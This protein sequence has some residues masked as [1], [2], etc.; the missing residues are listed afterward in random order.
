MIVLKNG[1][2]LK[3][4]A[5]MRDWLPGEAERRRHLINRIMEKISL[6]GY[7]EIATPLLEYCHILTKGEKQTGDDQLYKLVD[8]DGSVL[9]LR[10]EMTIPIAR[11][12]GS[13]KL[14]T[15]PL[16]LMYGGQ[17]FRYEN[18][19]AGRLREF[20]QVGVELI[21]EKGPEADGEI[22]ALVIEALKC[23][24]L[25]EFT[26]SLG[27]T[28]VLE[29]LQEGLSWREEDLDELR[30]L[31]LEKDFAG[32]C[33]LFEKAGMQAK[34]Q[35]E[36][37]RLLTHPVPLE[38]IN[39]INGGLPEGI[40]RALNEL[41]RMAEVLGLYGY[42]SYIQVDLST[43]RRQAYYSG[44]VFEIYTAG[45]GYPIGG[46]GRYD[47]LLQLFGKKCPATGFALGIERL[48]LSLQEEDAG[49]KTI[50]LAGT[51]DE[52]DRKAMVEK[53]RQL[54]VQ[55]NAAVVSLTASDKEEAE[56]HAVRINAELIWY[57]GGS[58]DEI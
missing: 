6:W 25:K 50:L 55:G 19:Q 32:L 26:V 51:G 39:E 41:K 30:S 11:V 49:E 34:K 20:N 40:E 1:N 9:A 44:M 57:K 33:H 24:G 15:V 31:I 43:L 23:I 3:I 12:L 38:R 47:N 28:G 7:R 42:E 22:L 21:G 29:G 2:N 36:L 10:P 17:V 18:V 52:K 48:L 27:H 35:E 54:R 45:L 14:S 37:I 5:G 46:G 56:R 13:K 53:A 4:P 58:N 16:R 8:R